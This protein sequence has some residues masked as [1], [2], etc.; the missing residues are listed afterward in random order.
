MTQQ[1]DSSPPNRPTV[2]KLLSGPQLGAEVP[3][4]NG[5]YL[6]GSDDD[7]DVVLL[8]DS[9]APHH[10][11]LTIHNGQ[12]VVTAQ[13][14]AV[15]IGNQ[16]L[17]PGAQ[18]EIPAGTVIGLGTTYIGLGPEETDWLNL[19]L[20]DVVG[21]R[22]DSTPESEEAP[23]DGDDESKGELEPALELEP[24]P[25]TATSGLLIYPDQ[26]RTYWGR[27]LAAFIGLAI[28]LLLVFRQE[29]SDWWETDA[30]VNADPGPSP[31][32]KAQAIVTDL[33]LKDIKLSV[34]K[35]GTVVL[36][37]YCDTTATKTRL[38][39]A[40]R[41]AGITVENRIWPEDWLQST[42]KEN[43]ASTGGWTTLDP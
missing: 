42:L 33:G 1:N 19:T 26:P 31:Q 30:M 8:D 35:D 27:W 37:G 43:P 16:S 23:E 34:K 3:L 25:D 32:E 6:I 39:K 9:V 40:L 29:L 41:A 24:E 36:H 22:S 7:A 10:A 2:L 38:N 14:Q 13:D 18:G 5:D 21:R 12:L 11:R 20:P 4:R 17:K 28:I 15:S